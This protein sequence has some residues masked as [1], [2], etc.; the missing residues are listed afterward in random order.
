V[1]THTTGIAIRR[2]VCLPSVHVQGG[3]I[4]TLCARATMPW[5]LRVWIVRAARGWRHCVHLIGCGNRSMN[6]TS[7]QPAHHTTPQQLVHILTPGS[8]RPVVIEMSSIPHEGRPQRKCWAGG[9]EVGPE[10]IGPE[11][12]ARSGSCGRAT[13]RRV[14]RRLSSSPRLKTILNLMPRS[15]L[16]C[17]CLTRHFE[18][19]SHSCA[20][21]TVIHSHY[22][23]RL[24]RSF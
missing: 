1:R 16:W 8:G 5:T 10:E 15:L 20:Q 23:R 24:P 21:F 4:V 2:R 22:S 17:G 13:A 3:G 14:W 6:A 18:I 7:R 19:C 12:W 9:L 11:A